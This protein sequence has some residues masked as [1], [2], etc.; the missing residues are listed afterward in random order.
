MGKS[1]GFEKV[2]LKSQREQVKKSKTYHPLLPPASAAILRYLHTSSLPILVSALVSMIGQP[3]TPAS[4]ILPL[5]SST[6][7]SLT[8]PSPLLSFL[9]ALVSTTTYCALSLPAPDPKKAAHCDER[10]RQRANEATSEASRKGSWR[11]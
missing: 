11:C 9:S 6:T 1:V 8:L 5:T 10:A 7:F 2:V 4:L 3:P